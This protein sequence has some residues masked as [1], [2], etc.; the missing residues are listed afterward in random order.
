MGRGGRRLQRNLIVLC[1][2]TGNEVEGDLS[3]VL[4]L[5]RM[6]IKDE[7]QKVF[8]EPGV[9][10]IGDDDAW[11]RIRRNIRSVWGLATGMGLDDNILS[12]YR[13]LCS[14]HEPGDRIFLFGFSRGA[15]TVRALAGLI[16]MV[17]LLYPE[18]SNLANYALTSYK[19]SSRL[20]DLHI[21]W[22]FK[23][24]VGG[25]RATIH[26]LGL[27]DT[28][29]SMIVPRPD[30]LYLPSLQ[31]LPF[32][33]ENPSVRA[34]RHAM[35]IDERRRMFR[36]NRWVD[37]Q[38]FVE[39]PFAEPADRVAQDVKQVWF[40]GVHADIGGG[41]PELESGLSKFPLL[42]MLEEAMVYRKV[43]VD[44]GP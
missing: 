38:P 5:Y 6:A 44:L 1:D 17:G 14:V 30:R 3:N 25:R 20:D 41:Y 9:G 18:Q 31:R 28:V 36:M 7:R 8:Y 13:F 33:R 26:F 37:D 16:H 11:A 24:I 22:D 34:V 43:S 2:G 27:W 21:A 19:R 40:M 29:A 15:Y 35:A 42:W 23:R 39:D 4:K 10:T 32:T 12:A